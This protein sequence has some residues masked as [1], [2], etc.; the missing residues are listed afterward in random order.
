MNNLSL[1]K[2]NPRR[3]IEMYTETKKKKNHHQNQ[4]KK[5]PSI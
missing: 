5:Y 2:E 1:E 4:K 3:E